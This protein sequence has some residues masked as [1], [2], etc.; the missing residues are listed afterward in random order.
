MKTCTNCKKEKTLSDFHIRAKS[1]DGHC[2][3][4][5][6]CISK[7]LKIY[8]ENN[9]KE[10]SEKKKIYHKLIEN[11]RKRYYIENKKIISEKKKKYNFKNKEKISTQKKEYKILNKEKVKIKNTN[12][13]NNNKNEH[14]KNVKLY[15]ESNKEKIKNYRKQ[16][17]IENKDKLNSNKREYYNK[18]IHIFIWRSLLKR[19]LHQFNNK[20][21]DS[22][23]NLLGYT[24]DQ[25]R[26]HIEN[27]FTENMCW[28]NYGEWHID[29]IRPVSTFNKITDPSIVNALSNLRPLWATNVEINGI[30]YEGNLNRKIIKE[31]YV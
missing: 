10:I 4:C 16:Y 1:K 17:Y 20:K 5:K 24:C 28:L 11:K 6:D 2:P 3:E 9:K 27:Q 21:T 18:N 12:W 30:F 7:K 25:L 15:S 13:Y 19:T 31:D 23:Y 8:N 22:T 29:H 14:K 26:T